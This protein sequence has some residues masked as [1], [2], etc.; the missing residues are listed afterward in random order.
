MDKAHTLLENELEQ[1]ASRY[2]VEPETVLVIAKQC[3][4]KADQIL[5]PEAELKPALLCLAVTGI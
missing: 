3:L 5:Y 2:E 4:G 1:L